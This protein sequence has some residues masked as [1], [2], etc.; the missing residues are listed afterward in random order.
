MEP[1][2]ISCT[3]WSSL[4]IYHLSA[5]T[6]FI[7]GHLLWVLIALVG[8]Q[9]RVWTTMGRE[10]QKRKSWSCLQAAAVSEVLLPRT[11]VLVCRVHPW[12][13]LNS[14]TRASADWCR[15]KSWGHCSVGTWKLG[16]VWNVSFYLPVA[17]RS[18]QE[19][20]FCHSISYKKADVQG[21]HLL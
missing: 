10:G 12:L 16:L 9:A 21:D 6:N 20:C 1:L 2:K 13:T 4:S 3:I 5:L 8:S 18:R 14:M 17:P 11:A 19:G 15:R 7:P